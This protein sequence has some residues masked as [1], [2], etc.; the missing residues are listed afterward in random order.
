MH[1]LLT[2]AT[3]FIGTNLVDCLLN[4]K[5]SV[6]VLVLPETLGQLPRRAQLKVVLGGLDDQNALLRATKDIGVVFHLA[7]AVPGSSPL[8]LTQVNVRGT[9]NLL[10]K[11]KASGVRRFV[12]VSSA[13]VYRPALSWVHR[14]ITENSPLGPLGNVALRTYGQSK[15][16]AERLVLKYY[17][18]HGL[19]FSILRPTTAFGVRQ[20]VI[21]KRMEDFLFTLLQNA[22][23]VLY[24]S[25][26]GCSMQWVHVRDLANAIICAGFLPESKNQVFTIAGDELFNI[27]QLTAIMLDIL[28]PPSRIKAFGPHVTL[29]RYPYLVY[30]TTKARRLLGYKPQVDLRTGLSEMI[31]SMDRN[32]RLPWS[33]SRRRKVAY[34]G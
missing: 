16:E 5:R 1:I 26:L 21:A 9:A 7:G 10:E 20:G 25:R 15:I 33:L 22:K 24:G 18:N 14:P 13:A 6:T 31:E 12:F 4:Q 32:G 2:G 29:K 3:G 34:C 8:D 27:P 19:E 30:D 23:S 28:S 11:C 17:Q